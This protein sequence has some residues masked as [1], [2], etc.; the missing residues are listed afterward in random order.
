[1]VASAGFARGGRAS[2]L[3]MASATAIEPDAIAE[4]FF[5]HFFTVFLADV[6]VRR[7]VGFMLRSCYEGGFGEAVSSPTAISGMAS[8]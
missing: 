1:M 7:R 2:A 3:P 5:A 4:D 6:V 8:S